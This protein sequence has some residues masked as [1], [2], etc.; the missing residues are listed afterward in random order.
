M[1]NLQWIVTGVVLFGGM[2]LAGV[3]LYVKRRKEKLSLDKENE[4]RI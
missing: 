1:I 4:F 3:G 2:I